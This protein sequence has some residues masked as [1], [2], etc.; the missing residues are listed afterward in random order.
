MEYVHGID[1]QGAIRGILA[2]GVV[3]L[4]HRLDCMGMEALFP[5]GHLLY[6]P[7]A[8]DVANGYCAVFGGLCHHMFDQ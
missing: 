6:R 7:V 1:D 2:G 3:E 5:A 4:L 8:V